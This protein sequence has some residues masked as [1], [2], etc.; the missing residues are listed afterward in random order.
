MPVQATVKRYLL[1]YNKI[2]AAH[3]PSMQSLLS[4]LEDEGFHLSKRTVERN[5]T[6]M[7]D[8]FGIA[9]VYDDMHKGYYIDEENSSGH[10]RFI[11]LLEII[12]AAQMIIG[13]L[14][15]G[16]DAL[17]YISFDG[18]SQMKGIQYLDNIL[19]A[20]RENH[21]I[22]F[23]HQNFSSDK[24]KIVSLK[25]Y[26]LK[27]YKQR[28]YV[29]GIG[30]HYS[31]YTIYGI[32]RISDLEVSNEKFRRTKNENSAQ[33]FDDIIGI[34]YDEHQEEEVILSFTPQQGKYIKTLPVHTSQNILTDNDQE[35]RISLYLR[36]NFEMKQLLLSYGDQVKIIEPQWL[37]E[38][39]TA[40]YKNA[41]NQY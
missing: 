38:E 13:T 27:E 35:L 16:R 15:D 31:T 8:E 14:K 19:K 10:E 25:P 7:R 36:P 1:L 12:T 26:L 37:K 24:P 2:K 21:T 20:I 30:A 33:L 18:S 11:R 5:F 23:K 9:I 41:I 39:I 4:Y 22:K 29:V 32:D 6:Q 34:N 28:W 3:Y 17:K 40:I